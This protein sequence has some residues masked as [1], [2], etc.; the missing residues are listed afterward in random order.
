MSFFIMPQYSKDT[1]VLPACIR[2]VRS[3]TAE[4]KG[5]RIERCG[6]ISIEF[7]CFRLVLGV[8]HND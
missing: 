6:F 1:I 2:I 3:G 8:T 7:L 5:G 4:Y